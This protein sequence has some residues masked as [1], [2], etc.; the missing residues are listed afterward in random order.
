MGVGVPWFVAALYHK[1]QVTQ[2][3]YLIPLGLVTNKVRNSFALLDVLSY[4]LRTLNVG[5]IYV[6]EPMLASLH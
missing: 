2:L 6:W 5:N 4:Q 1:T 3:H